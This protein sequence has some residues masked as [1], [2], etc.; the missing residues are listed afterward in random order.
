[1]KQLSIRSKIIL[2]LLLSGL[3]ALAIGGVLGY[4]SGA[5]ALGL[6]V[7]EKL[8]AQ[9]E[10]KK[11]RVE[12]YITNQLRFTEALAGFPEIGHAAHAM[13]SAYR[14]MGPLVRSDPAAML[15]DRAVLEGWYSDKFFPMLDKVAGGHLPVDGMIPSD[16]VARRLQADYIARNPAPDGQRRNMVV[17][18]GGSP[19]D[20]AHAQ[21]HPRLKFI[22]QT[23]GFYDINILDPET[24]RIVYSIAKDPDFATSINDGAFSHS[25]L[26]E[27]AR[28]ALDPR[29]A[30]KAV[31]QDYTA[32]LPAGFAPQMFTA[33]PLLQNG[34]V[35]G[36]LVAQI[37]IAA[38]NNV[39]TDNGLWASTGQGETGEVVLVGADHIYRNQSRF[40]ATDPTKFLKEIAANGVPE[41]VVNQIRALGTTILLLPS[42]ARGIDDA[43]RNQTGQLRFRDARGVEVI[44]AFGPLDVA[45]LHWAILAKQDVA[46]A[47]EPEMRLKR[48]LT[49]AAALAAIVLTFVAMVCSTLFMRPMRQVIDSM[50]AMI[51]GG[52]ALQLT[53]HGDD[54]FAELTRGYNAMAATLES[55]QALLVEAQARADGLL[56]ELYPEALAEQV[57][58]GAELASE[59]V[60]NLSVVVTWMDGLDAL[61]SERSATELNDILVQLLGA[62]NQ[63]A[64]ELGLETVTSLGS[65]HIAVCGLS[66]A[67][68]DHAM[69]VLAWTTQAS[70]AVRRL[71][72]DWVERVSLRFGMASGSLDVLLLKRGHV[73]YDIWGRPL[74]I[75]RRIV[76]EAAPATV[77]IDE[78]AYALLTDVQGVQSAPPI[79]A[80]V[81][82]VLTTWVRQVAT[83]PP[84][85]Q[86]G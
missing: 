66:S 79:D 74:S 37:D 78:S 13:I 18:P 54:E 50:R 86:G 56:H 16:P 15:Q 59:T 75:A 42:N 32:Y 4:R 10:M 21:F 48:A 67:R 58:S 76:L 14:E 46:E 35:I 85:D 45:G 81:L 25:G 28:R 29:N 19:Y 82:G 2:T 40:M 47:L 34:R 53:V 41:A 52:H 3:A 80:P 11:V 60:A 12:T 68:M 51:A 69:R 84:V 65:S 70:Q 20:I 44:G 33:I 71:S 63:T 49:V 9:R 6:S 24:G 38:L 27:V 77:R 72:G 26:S 73:A 64:T 36:V 1:M 17:A 31:V 55:R 5:E 8:M 7:R 39:L 83:V 62:L 30:G 43:L 23:I 61:A 22:A 57:R